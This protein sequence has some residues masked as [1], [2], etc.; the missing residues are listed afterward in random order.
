M[1]KRETILAV[2]FVISVT[3]TTGCSTKKEKQIN[4]KG[5]IT[6]TFFTSD[7]VE[8]MPFTDP[9][10]QEIA[11]RTGVTLEV[12]HPVAGDT[13]AVP[14]MMASGE[15]DDL[16]YAKGELTKL[17]DANAIIPL[18]DYVDPKSNHINLIE[19][20]GKNMKDLYGDQLV[21]LKNADGHIYSFGTYDVKKSILQTSGTLQI[22]HAVLQELGYPKI[23]SLNDYANVLRTYMKKY[24]TIDGKTTI[25]LSLLIDTWQWYIDLSNPGGYVLGY[26][27]DGQWIV[28][29]KTNTAQYKFL[30]KDIWYYY[31][32]LN[33]LNEEG[34]LD[35]ESFTQ[36]EDVWKAK[37][38]SG[39]VLGIA[40][41]N[42]GYNDARQSLISAG[43]P[44]RTYAYLP[45][46][47]DNSKY[48][49]PSLFDPGFSGGWGIGI[50]TS[51]KDP[52][53]AFK[54]IDWMCSE[55]TQILTNWG[56]KDIN[57]II[58]NG[59]RIVSSEEQHQADTDPDYARKTGVGRWVYP[60]P[61]RGSGAV[62]K[63]GDWITRTS[64]QRIIDNYLPVEKKTLAAYGAEMW[65]DL[66]PSTNEL[67]KTAYG[68]LWQYTLPSDVNEKLTVADE[69][70]KNALAQCVLCKPSDFD[71]KWNEMQQHLRDIGMDTAGDEVTALIKAKLKLWGIEK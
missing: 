12:D 13:Q 10:A 51:C 48:K 9:V 26:P 40:Y 66:F 2:V 4:D 18:D 3:L 45:I 61:E 38:A 57:Y 56:I 60:F 70:V 47:A 69:Y 5:P 15:Y 22:Q 59:K 34:I 54:F 62:D 43:K 64:K 25:G 8:D 27:D 58:E 30:K 37:I 67:G 49:D 39:R 50:S 1:I 33:K 23:N 52:I 6:F 65:V 42:W 31:K 19:K 11:K 24:P 41:P 16:I 20:Y 71:K 55:N 36:K 28:D 63:N 7:A 29:R 21:K 35:P 46:T 53:R 32:W 17:I 14:L 68:Q 44:E